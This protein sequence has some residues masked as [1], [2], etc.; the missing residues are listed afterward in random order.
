M[1]K[2][3]GFATMLVVSATLFSSTV[4]AQTAIR[5]QDYLSGLIKPVFVTNA[6]DNSKRLFIVEKGGK[7]KVVQ[8]GSNTTTDFLNISTILST[9]GER[10]LLGLAFHPNYKTNRRFFVYYTRADGDI[11]IA[12]YQASA[13]DPNVADTTGKVIIT[14]EHSGADNHNGGTIG[15]GADGFLYAGTGDGGGGNDPS[16]N[17]QNINQLLGKFIRLN[18]DV[19]ASET[20]PYSVP[21]DNPFVGRDGADE[22]FAVG[23]RNPYRWSF[24]RGGTRQLW[25]ADVGQGLIEEVDIITRGAN[26]GWRVYEGNS[27]TNL[28]PALCTNP[29]GFTPPIFEYN[30][31]GGRCSITGGYVYRGTRQVL[32]NGAYVYGDYCTGEIFMYANGQQSAALSN[33]ADYNLVSFGEDEVGELY[34]VGINSKTVQKIVPFVATAGSG[35][36]ADIETRP[37]GNGSV[38]ADDVVM[39]RLFVNRAL[40]PDSA[41][42]EFQRADSAPFETKG[43]GF[44]DSADIVQTRLYANRANTLQTAGGQ[45]SS[46]YLSAHDGISPNLKLAAAPR[47]LQIESVSSGRNQQVTIAVKVDATGSEAEYGFSLEYDPNTLIN[48]QVENGDSGAIIQNCFVESGKRLNCSVGAFPINQTDSNDAGIGEIGAGDN[49]TL[50]KITFS[51][52]AN[53]PAGQTALA[54]TNVNASNDAA[55]SLTD[56]KIIDGTVTVNAAKRKRIRLAGM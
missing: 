30:H 37:G 52:A 16:D 24:D 36:E 1:R 43:D 15:F 49:Q 8:S 32:P 26:Y 41:T 11:Q 28:D 5:V 25:A 33:G 2:L 3:I 7:I 20:V 23:L 35:V 42:N 9:S 44:I 31:T 4:F 6:G 14:I 40:T 22:I 27:C 54:L 56:F 21:A 34:V 13:T 48:P 12:E 38:E 50:V 17:A 46:N 10:G 47:G 18:V 19:P 51:V 29:N 55:Q 39:I 53:A 45:T